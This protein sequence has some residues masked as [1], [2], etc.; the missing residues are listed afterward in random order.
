MVGELQ[1]LASAA[2]VSGEERLLATGRILSLARGC[3]AELDDYLSPNRCV[4]G[5]SHPAGFASGAGARCSGGH[6][7]APAAGGPGELDWRIRP[8]R[9]G[10]GAD[11]T[12]PLP[13]G[14]LTHIVTTASVGEALAPLKRMT[15]RRVAS[16]A[17]RA[18][19]YNPYSVLGDS[20]A[21]VIAPDD[22]ESARKGG[23][24]PV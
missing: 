5:R 22:F 16:D 4:A 12:S 14:G 20:A 6:H 18:F 7:H 3:G 9:S 10:S 24:H 2:A 11:R 1:K 23:G 17:A 15:G 13:E 8:Q 21:D 19:L